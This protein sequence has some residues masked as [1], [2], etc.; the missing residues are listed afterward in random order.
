MNR[1]AAIMGLFAF[2]AFAPI[3]HAQSERGP[4]PGGI[5]AA[6]TAVERLSA[7]DSIHDG[8]STTPNGLDGEREEV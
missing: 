6:P 7:K 4:E 8:N 3:G 5:S 1:L 2:L